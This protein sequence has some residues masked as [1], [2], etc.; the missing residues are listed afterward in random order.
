[1]PKNINTCV[2]RLSLSVLFALLSSSVVLSQ[3]S[4]DSLVV[5]E[6]VILGHKKTRSSIIFREMPFGS[7]DRLAIAELPELVA[8]A[9]NNLMNT[10]LFVRVDIAYADWQPPDN[11]VT[12]E[13]K[14]QETW[15]L[16]PVPIFEL[17]D[18]NFNVW[19]SEQNRSLDRVNFGLKFTHYNFSG[20]RDRLRLAFQYGYTREY[21]LGYRLPYLG[22]E[23][24]LGLEIDWSYARRR[25]QNYATLDNQQL[26][27]QNRDDFVYRR[28]E[29]KVSTSYRRRLYTR[30][31][32]TAAWRHER[33]ADTIALELNPSFFGQGRREQDFI[34]LEYQFEHDHRDVRGYPWTG[35]YVR[36]QLNKAGLGLLGQRNGFTFRGDYRRYTPIGRRFSLNTSVALKYSL[37]R[38]QQPFLDNQALG[39]GSNT[40]PGYQFYVIDGLD[41][42][43]LRTGLR[44]ELIRSE[45]NLPKLVF[46]DAF[47]RIPYRVLAAFQ[48]DQGW[49]NMPFQGESNDLANTWLTGMAA[50]IDVV[51]YFDMAL[52][53]RYQRNHLRE[54]AFL[55]EFD[56]NF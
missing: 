50:G 11:R 25:E 38:E 42:V 3:T 19:W 18:R 37:V 52:S 48:F 30:H 2:S 45:I 22:K 56:A 1:M 44:W 54:G 29:L 33:I 13:V 21:G 47:R 53:F 9:E 46:I 51:L 15:Y 26:F 7:G 31:S 16:F 6:V 43:I 24:N 4:A 34:W 23:K 20:R 14:V 36:L 41:M 55:I 40:L 28:S 10:G 39:F 27:Y 32:F 8:A 49:A 35:D 17:A 12:F 5:E